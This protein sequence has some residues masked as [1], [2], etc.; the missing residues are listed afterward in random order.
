MV[1]G[2]V[3]ESHCE[4]LVIS[5][6]NW[7]FPGSGNARLAADKGGQEV[8]AF[9]RRARQAQCPLTIGSAMIS[10]SGKLWDKATNA[11]RLLIM[12]VCVGYQSWD[13]Q[14]VHQRIL[15]TPESVYQA[16]LAALR[17]A[18]SEHVQSIALPLMCA[19]PGYSTVAVHEAKQIM[20]GQMISAINDLRSELSMDA[21]FIYGD[22]EVKDYAQNLLQLTTA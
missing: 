5:A 22:Q 9:L 4:C 8:T 18:S 14:N 21:V 1:T 15:A 12:A 6:N 10:P 19:R 13:G 20:L 3:T 7:L 11:R 16:T 17:L 2:N